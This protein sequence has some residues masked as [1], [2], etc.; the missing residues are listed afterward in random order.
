MKKTI[1]SF[2]AGIVFASVIFFVVSQTV[3][4]PD[5]NEWLEVMVTHNIRFRIDSWEKRYGI[6][7][8]IYEDKRILSIGITAANGEEQITDEEAVVIKPQIE[9]IAEATLENYKWA[10]NYTVEVTVL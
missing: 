4:L 7:P 1:S 2:I 3:F 5:K 9:S 8:I 6:T 10:K